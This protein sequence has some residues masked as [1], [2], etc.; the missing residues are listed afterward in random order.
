MSLLISGAT[1]I[2]GVSDAPLAGHSIW[3][4]GRRIKA[5]TRGAEVERVSGARTINAHGKYIIPGLMDANV[6]L[7]GDVRLENV[8]RY[9]GRYEDLILEAAQ[10]A[11]KSGLTTVFDTFGPRQPLISVRDKINSGE[12]PGSRIFC[13]GNIIGLDGVISRD[14]NARALDVAS[15]ALIERLNG[16]WASNVGPALSWMTPEQV[17]REVRAYIAKGIDFVKYAS[18][19]HRWG[20]PTTFLVFSAQSQAAIV[21]AAHEAG[22]T[23]QAHATSVE[24]LR[25][26]VEAGCDLIQHCNITGPVPIPDSTLELIAQRG[27]GAVVFPFTRRRF[28][29]ILEKCPVDRPYFSTSDTNCRNLIQA[30]ARVLLA[31]DAFVMSSEFLTDPVLTQ[32]WSAPG[33]DNLAELGQGHFH[34]LKAMEEKGFPPMELLRAATR[35]IARAYGK[36]ADLGTLQ[37][38]KLADLLILEKNPL[39]SADNYRSIDTIIRD[40][41]VVDRTPLPLNPLL[42]LPA[43]AASAETLAY[44]AQRH[45][46]NSRHPCCV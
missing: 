18:S 13:A 33:E 17:A 25:V 14:F 12:V 43:A 16:I 37:P 34:W 45:L 3:I 23:A 2:D 29:W 8:V 38:G 35:N 9:E 15:G 26:A 28:D 24:S 20:D 44:R 1:I 10:I 27:T 22:I 5:I 7:M 6:H 31:T 41:A 36:D 42:T 21:N 30:G 39:E 11:L 32:Y 19:E 46:G 4:E 40:G